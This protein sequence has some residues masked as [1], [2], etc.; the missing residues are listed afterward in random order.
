MVLQALNNN[1]TNNN[2]M[3]ATNPDSMCVYVSSEEAEQ[4][5]R[6]RKICLVLPGYFQKLK[7][8]IDFLKKIYILKI[9]IRS[10]RFK[11]LA[12]TQNICIVYQNEPSIKKLIVRQKISST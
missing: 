4:T 6:K 8:S 2:N 1:A 12:E 9:G 5:K 10:A 11:R 7:K 3:T